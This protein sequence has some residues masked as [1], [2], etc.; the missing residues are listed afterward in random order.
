MIKLTQN[1]ILHV[2]LHQNESRFNSFCL[3]IWFSSVFITI[4]FF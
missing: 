3:Y 4:Y 1:K 2:F